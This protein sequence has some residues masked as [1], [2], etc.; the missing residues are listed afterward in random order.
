[1][2]AASGPTGREPL[3]PAGV[4]TA[5]PV[6]AR[7]TCAS[8]SSG[9]LEGMLTAASLPPAETGLKTTSKVRFPPAGMVWP[10]ALSF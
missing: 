1:M 7:V 9:S 2:P 8:A 6:P 4:T 5:I 3:S 10:E